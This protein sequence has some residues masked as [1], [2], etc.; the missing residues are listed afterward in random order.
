MSFLPFFAF[1]VAIG[2]HSQ[3]DVELSAKALFYN[4]AG[5]VASVA[6]GANAPPTTIPSATLATAETNSDPKKVEVK[7]TL[8]ILALRASILLVASDGGTRE[9]KPSY[10]F[11]SGDR[12]KLG[13]T[14]NKSGY[15]YLATLGTSGRVQM[16]APRK[17]EAAKL[18]AGNRYTFPASS[19]GYFRMDGPSGKEELWAV[20][21]DEPLDAIN[22]GSG[23]MA[24]IE[25]AAL[26]GSQP[27]PKAGTAIPANRVSNDVTVQLASK[28]LVFEEDSEAA[29]ASIKP[30][31]LVKTNTSAIPTI[32]I[33]LV[34]NH[35]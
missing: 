25:Q 11:K 18:T 3:N 33:K 8:P 5:D 9:V 2:A 35:L 14:T 13:F 27:P 19:T 21:S 16:L 31:S 28:D 10:Q 7:K 20:L 12:V 30:A 4:T 34:L 26:N 24:Y 17:G 29:Y 32:E 1:C 22:M 23:Q 6:S 15:F